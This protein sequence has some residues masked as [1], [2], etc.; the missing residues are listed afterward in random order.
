VDDSAVMRKVF[1]RG[2]RQAGLDIGDIIEAGD[3]VD[4]LAALEKAPGVGLV[5]CD[6]NMPN[7]NGVDF[8]AAARAKGHRMPIVMITTEA[9]AERIQQ[10][11]QAGANG[12]LTKPFT[13]EKLAEYLGQL[14]A[15]P[16]A[17]PA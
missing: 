6:W 10:A 5:L 15:A 4:A 17:H 13:P 7:M 11:T 12:F 2:L 16:S 3:G 14:L 8:V 9:G 1:M